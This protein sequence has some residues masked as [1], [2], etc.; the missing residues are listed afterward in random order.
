MEVWKDFIRKFEEK[1]KRHGR[2]RGFTK[3]YKTQE[4]L[5][6]ELIA[7]VKEDGCRLCGYKKHKGSI[8][9]HH[10]KKKSPI[11]KSKS[12]RTKALR[13]L[14]LLELKE[15]IKRCIPVC[16][17]CHQEIHDAFKRL[18]IPPEVNYPEL[19]SYLTNID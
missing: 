12:G 6:L 19:K 9:L 8:D 4:E 1:E 7:R 17:N 16:R 11:M 15:E 14:R 5:K 10:V 2:K 3:G 13:E 18:K